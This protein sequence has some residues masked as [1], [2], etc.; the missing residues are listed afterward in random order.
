MQCGRCGHVRCST[1]GASVRG[2]G[3]CPMFVS[4]V[5]CRVAHRARAHR[6]HRCLPTRRHAQLVVDVLEVGRDRLAG[7]GE[8]CGDRR[9]GQPPGELDEYLCLPWRQPGRR[10]R[11]RSA[12]WTS[13]AAAANPTALGTPIIPMSCSHAAPRTKTVTHMSRPVDR[14]EGPSPIRGEPLPRSRR[15]ETSQLCAYPACPP[16]DTGGKAPRHRPG[17][18]P[19]SCPAD[20]RRLR[21]VAD[22]DPSPG[23]PPVVW[24][25]AD[26]RCDSS[27][28]PASRGGP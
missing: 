19:H 11:S 6:D 22:P 21:G 5:R 3:N 23:Q 9:I 26:V 4:E 25:G 20:R 28:L 14:Q 1:G 16:S 13:A 7:D 12:W 8:L 24:R 27:A 17:G 18:L 2:S 10:R 15:L